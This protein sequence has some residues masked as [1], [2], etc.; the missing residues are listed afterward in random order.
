MSIAL[1]YLAA[2]MSSRFGGK[3]KQFTPIGPNKE[4]LLEYSLQQALPC[5]FSQIHFIVGDKTEKMIRDFAGNNYQGIPVTYS[6]Q[7]FD[8]LQRHKPWGTVDALATI[9]EHVTTNFIVCNSDDI[10]GPE[11]FATCFDYLQKYNQ[12]V[13]VGFTLGDTMPKQGKVNRGF[14]QYDSD[15]FI[16]GLVENLGIQRQDFTLQQL[17]ETI[18][19]V[20]FLGLRPEVIDIMAEK[21]KIFKKVHAHNPTIESLIPTVIDELI[22]EGKITIKLLSSHRAEA[23]S[24][25]GRGQWYGVTNPEDEAIVREQIRQR[26]TLI[27]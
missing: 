15:N 23:R 12:N 16:T 9:K 11:T 14:F 27:K 26:H 17:Q 8:P 19:S 1:V 21:N 13:S 2:G 6:R 20:N 7:T 5:P 3:A 25:E 10:Y 18:I 4:T 22:K 24:S